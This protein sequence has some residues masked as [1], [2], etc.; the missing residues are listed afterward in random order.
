[1]VIW[2]EGTVVQNE[3]TLPCDRIRKD[4]VVMTSPL[5]ISTVKPSVASLSPVKSHTLDSLSIAHI[6]KHSNAKDGTLRAL[7]MSLQP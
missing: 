7:A 1:M 6:R 2:F 4:F 5:E 3:L